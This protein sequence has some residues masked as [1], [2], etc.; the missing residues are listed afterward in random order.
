MSLCTGPLPPEL[1]QL[2]NLQY[3]GVSNNAFT[4]AVFPHIPPRKPIATEA[5]ITRACELRP[6]HALSCAG[7]LPPEL[8][9][10]VNL[11]V[12]YLYEN[13]FSGAV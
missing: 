2:T 6:P 12:L 1:G 9:Q 11:T 13:N 10:L 5:K 8:G 4:G 3:L 7:T